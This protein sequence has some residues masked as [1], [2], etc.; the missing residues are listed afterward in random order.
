MEQPTDDPRVMYLIVRVSLGMSPGKM[1]AQVAHAVET[2]FCDYAQDKHSGRTAEESARVLATT[3]W[4]RTDRT[5]VVLAAK[6][7]EFERAKTIPGAVVVVDMGRTEVAPNTE[8]VI[9]LWPMRL[10]ERPNFLRR[11]RVLI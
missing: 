10:S 8:T 4:R 5:K 9:G 3:E 2:I 1:A 7:N 6:D 11:M